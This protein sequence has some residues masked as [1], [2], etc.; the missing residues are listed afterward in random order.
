M[1]RKPRISF[2][3]ALHHIIVRGN[4]KEKVFLYDN[5]R[6][7]FVELFREYHDRYLFKCYAYVLMPNHIHLLLEEGDTPLSKVMQGINQS[8]T[9]YFN[10]KY[11]KV[12]HLFQGRYKTILC[13][14]DRYLII[15]VRYIHLNPVHAKLVSHPKDF[16]WSSHNAY[17]CGENESFIE[18]EFVLSLF[19][20]KKKQA[21]NRYE[22]FIHD[23]MEGQIEPNF[24]IGS[25]LGDEEFVEKHIPKCTHPE[26][27]SKTGPTLKQIAYF[28]A[29]H[30]NISEQFL[31]I[32]SREKKLFE[33]R[34]LIGYLAC[35]YANINQKEIAEYFNR[36]TSTTC[37]AIQNIAGKFR[38][39]SEFKS[40]VEQL[41]EKLFTS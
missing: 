13:D 12:G 34:C 5:D 8:Y 24:E 33:I 31:H 35:K 2:P 16:K 11:K 29:D 26:T 10:T 20:L 21:I 30:F 28:V 15:L 25:F 9:Q 17:L 19:S 39:D 7:K 22:R 41:V 32:K 37:H 23:G 6:N 27:E 14:K 3:G 4:H 38:D 36:S 1:A 40:L 18:T